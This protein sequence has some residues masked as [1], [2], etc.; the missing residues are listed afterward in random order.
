MNITQIESVIIKGKLRIL[1]EHETPKCVLL[2]QQAIQN[3][4]KK[5]MNTNMIYNEDKS[6][7]YLI[8]VDEKVTVLK[9]PKEKFTLEELQE[10]VKGY[11]E[12]IYL[13]GNRVM[14]VNEEG[15]LKKL[16]NNL[17]ASFEAKRQIVGD[18]VVCPSNMID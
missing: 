11:I 5:I 7:A 16:S 18:V 15:R 1:Y 6:K 2:A 14:V 3:K 4:T 10:A 9:Q 13:S 17:L 8:G 12:L